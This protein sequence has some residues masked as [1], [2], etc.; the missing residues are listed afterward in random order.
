MTL[1]LA[2]PLGL[3]PE[4]VRL[5]RY[6]P[7]FETE[8]ICI[9]R[10][11]FPINWVVRFEY[12]RCTIDESGSPP[13]TGL[14]DWSELDPGLPPHIFEIGRPSCRNGCA[15]IIDTERGVATWHIVDGAP[16]FNGVPK[17][18]ASRVVGQ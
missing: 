14:E 5:L 17:P 2:K 15:L 16:P 3:D 6:I 10:E 12:Y 9:M 13:P 7:H 11:C 18:D 8:D 4:A 1:D